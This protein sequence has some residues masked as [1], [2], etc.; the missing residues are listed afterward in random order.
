[1]ASVF[2]LPACLIL[3]STMIL[4]DHQ[5]CYL[6]KADIKE[7]YRILLLNSF[8]FGRQCELYCPTV[9]LME[10]GC[11]SCYS[12]LEASLSYFHLMRNKQFVV[13]RKHSWIVVCCL[14]LASDIA[15]NPGPFRFP[16]TVCARPVRSNQCGIECDMCQKWSHTRCVEIGIRRW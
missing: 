10:F 2:N 14:M 6:I 15:I 11:R 1:M 9:N 12:R 7:A 16:C 3:Q 8:S 4:Q 5:G 13:V